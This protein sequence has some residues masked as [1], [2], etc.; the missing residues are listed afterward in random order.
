MQQRNQQLSGSRQ[1][2]L[3]RILSATLFALCAA[4][5]AL[6][7][8]AAAL[9]GAT[10]Q[11]AAVEALSSDVALQDDT[12][13]SFGG[14][15]RLVEVTGLIDPV[16]YDFMIKE[17]DKAEADDILAI[18]FL[19]NSN[20]SILSEER[21]LELAT[22]L[23]DSSVQIGMWVGPTGSAALGHTAEL[24]VTAD[25]VGVPQGSWVGDIGDPILS[26]DEFPASF[27]GYERLL[28][29]KVRDEEAIELGI[30]VGP[31]DNISTL[32]PFVS[33]LDGYETTLDAE[34]NRISVTTP[35]FVGLPLSGQLFHT[36]ASPEVAYLF[37]VLGLGILIFE[38][39]TA[40]VG[41]AGVIGVFLAVLGCYGLAV[42]PTNTWA[43]TLLILSFI[44]AAIDIQTNIPRFYSALS[45][46]LFVVASFFLYD[47]LSMSYVTAGF[48]I[49]G[50]ALYIYTGMP[51]M[52]RTRFSTPTIGR[53]WMIGSEAVA[54]TAIDPEGTVKIDGTPWRALTNRATP[55]A[56]GDTV[57]VV[58]IKR[59]LL[60]VAPVE[61]GAKD[62]RDR[63]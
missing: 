9:Q 48:G 7:G 24:L 5:M 30:S 18:V 50:M 21:F 56:E 19:L 44:A 57:R 52:V 8:P 3:R 47:G 4:T 32:R 22:R 20:G 42:L 36:V 45:M 2:S 41:V 58:G 43:L 60:E 51:S 23:R 37:F 29:D 40:G 16:M 1:Q 11:D 12:A 62:Y 33:Y 15:V 59:L 49:I 35:E 55:M 34:G 46:V 6:S 54:A 38:L 31:L 14:R 26:L 10:A 63:S 39:F 28:T 25:L 17:L 13:D 53:K 61:G 27:D